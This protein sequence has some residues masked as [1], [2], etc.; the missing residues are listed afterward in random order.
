MP[1]PNTRE[2]HKFA[3]GGFM[4]YVYIIESEMD[5]SY[6]I[7]YTKDLKK[8]LNGHNRG[9]TRFTR[10]KMPWK[11]KYYE[12]F[13]NKTDAIKREKHLKRQKSREFYQ[14]LFDNMVW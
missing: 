4:F 3:N 2:G 6:Y 7:G 8:R 13:N 10:T 9:Q 1:V 12:V 5:S 14:K 11:L